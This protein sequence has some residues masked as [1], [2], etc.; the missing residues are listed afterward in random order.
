MVDL[1][2]LAYPP[3]ETSSDW[4][5]YEAVQF[6]LETARRIKPDF[7][8]TLVNKGAIIR[9]CQLLAGLPLGLELAASWL[10][11]E[12]CPAIVAQIES[13]QDIPFHPLSD[14]P[15]RHQSLRAVFNH[16]LML[17]T[18]S[19]KKILCRLAIIRG[20]F[21]AQ[22]A[23]VVAE[24]TWPLI[25]SLVDKSLVQLAPGHSSLASRYTLHEM[26]RQ[27][28]VTQLDPLDGRGNAKTSYPVIF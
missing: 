14:L 15:E 4:Q 26:L 10:R 7:E 3:R 9:L 24:A 23:E 28:L 5:N 18:P 20:S 12:T 8:A 1:P 21:T 19:E 16:S 17:L 22:A 2:G 13:Q 25:F 6:L 11:I 27:Y